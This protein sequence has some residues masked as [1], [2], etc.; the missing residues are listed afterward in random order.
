LELE[1]QQLSKL[2]DDLRVSVTVW[3]SKDNQGK[4]YFFEAKGDQNNLV[5]GALYRLDVPNYYRRSRAIGLDKDM[6]IAFTKEG[7]YLFRMSSRDDSQQVRYYARKYAFQEGDV[8]L[9]R[10]NLARGRQTERGYSLDFIPVDGIE[11]VRQANE[12]EREEGESFEEYLTRRTR[13]FNEHLR[14]DPGDIR[15]WLDFAN[16][17]DEFMNLGKKY[18]KTAT[19]EKKIGIYNSGLEQNP[20]SVELLLGLVKDAQ[21]L[22]DADKMAAL[23]RRIMS[24]H[25]KNPYI[26]E[27]CIFE[28][29]LHSL[30]ERYFIFAVKFCNFHC[31]QFE[32][33]LCQMF[34]ESTEYCVWYL[35]IRCRRCKDS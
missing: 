19:L 35:N 10:L 6:G 32:G 5:Y 23:W 26:W 12:D 17:Q 28:F 27:A 4:V 3:Q 11:N 2:N 29:V 16:F 21:Q 30:R 34:T 13:I 1:K 7:Y 8:D 25:S 31:F 33:S 18:T 20:Y 22:W 15:A 24:D 9:K 14:D